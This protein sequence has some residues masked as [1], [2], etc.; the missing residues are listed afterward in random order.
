[1]ISREDLYQIIGYSYILKSKTAGVVYPSIEKTKYNEIGRLSG[2]GALI[3]KQSIQIPQQVD[4]YKAFITL[5]K[6]SENKFKEQ[7]NI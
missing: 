4:S 7:W 6:E 1:G 2:Y 5:M 3:F